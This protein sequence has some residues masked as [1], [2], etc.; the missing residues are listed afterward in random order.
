MQRLAQHV[1]GDFCGKRVGCHPYGSQALLFCADGLALFLEVAP[2]LF[3]HQAKFTAGL[4]QAQIG[5]VLPQQQAVFRPAGEHAVRF[6]DAAGGQV[7]D[8]Y[9]DIGLV[10]ARAPGFMLP[11]PQGRV[12]PGYQSLAGCLFIAGRAVYLAG[13]KQSGDEPG[14]QPRVQV[15]GVEIIVFYGIPRPGDMSLLEPLDRPHQVLLHVI[16]QAGGYAVGIDFRRG[17]PF[18]FDKDLVGCP[19]G[20]AYDLVLHRGAVTRADAFNHAAV[21]GRTIQPGADDVMGT[22]IGMGDM[23]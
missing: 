12:D 14:F 22:L 23:A 2:P 3:I 1:S 10:A 18:R 8:Q 19:V 7:I 21:H 4:G 15:T 11:D 13:K 17:Q 16:G 6:R 20:K 5:V 9:A